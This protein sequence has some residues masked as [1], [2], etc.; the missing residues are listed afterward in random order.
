RVADVATGK[1]RQIWLADEGDGSVFRGIVADDQLTWAAGDRIVFPWEKNGWTLLYS[2]PVDGRLKPAATL[3]TPGEL[4]VEHVSVSPDRREIV[5]ASNQNDVDRRHVWRVLADGSKPP[6]QVTSGK[7]IEWS[8][9]FVSANTIAILRSDAHVPSH[10][11]IAGGRDLTSPPARF[12]AAQLVEPQPV[13]VVAT[14][15]MK[16]HAQL[17]APSTP[18]QHPAAVFVHGG[19]RRQMLIGW[20]YMYY[21]SNAYAMNQ[22]LASRGYVVLSV[23]YRSGIGYGMKFR[24]A[25]NYGTRGASE[26]NDVIGAGLYLR[27]R[28][29]VDPGKIVAWGGSYG[30]YLTAFALAKASN[31]FAAGADFHGVHDWNNEIR[32]WE[33]TYDP[34]A[35]EELARLAFQSSPIAYVD[36]WKSPVLLI[37]G[38]DDRNVNFNETIHLAEELRKRNVD[39]ELL[40]FPD[41][42]HDFLLHRDW[43]AAYKATADF[44]E[45]K[46]R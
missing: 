1:G 39:V 2:V 31:L 41:E 40:V 34:R 12:P 19:S 45:R 18:G 11:A 6:V 23:N 14:D 24:E 25:D 38:D 37:Q 8:P 10:A 33:P 27:S 29:D 35:H 36:A 28:P 46:L 17:F 13:T 4:E 15:G 32:V 3:L 7:G 26:V 42:V 43:L 5:Y 9:R 44:F 21:Y 30:G 20:H 22:Y 16:I